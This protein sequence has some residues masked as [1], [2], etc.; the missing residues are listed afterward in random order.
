MEIAE[1]LRDKG[2]EVIA[3]EPNVNKEEV[4]G[5]KLYSLEEILK[6]ADYLI[7]AQGHREFKENIQLLKTKNIYDCLGI[8]K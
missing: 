5:F 6:K 3:C 2:Y 4:D 8:L 1:I 7:L